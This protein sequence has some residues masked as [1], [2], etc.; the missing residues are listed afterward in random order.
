[1]PRLKALPLLSDAF[2]GEDG[3]SVQLQAAA[4]LAESLATVTAEFPDVRV[5]GRL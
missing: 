4:V 3:S 2:G 1:M 5:T